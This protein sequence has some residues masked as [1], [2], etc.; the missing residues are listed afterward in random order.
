MKGEGLLD[1]IEAVFPGHR[2]VDYRQI[3]TAGRKNPESLHAVGG[4]HYLDDIHGLDEG[5]AY[6]LPHE[7][8]IV[9]YQNAHSGSFRPGGDSRGRLSPPPASS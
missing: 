6:A 4:F 5:L 3:E 2:H 9:S 7:G 8:V 1:E